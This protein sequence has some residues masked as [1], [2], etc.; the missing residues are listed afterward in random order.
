MLGTDDE[1]DPEVRVTRVLAAAARN[2]LA[3]YVSG[4]RELLDVE[5][6]RRRLDEVRSAQVFAEDAQDRCYVHKGLLSQAEA[7]E[8]ATARRA[9]VRRDQVVQS[10]PVRRDTSP[11]EPPALSPG[12]LARAVAAVLLPAAVGFA[13]AALARRFGAR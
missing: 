2:R 10:L 5:E 6:A 3:E 13:G 8:R 9:P 11:A 1:S 4:S 7:E 12:E